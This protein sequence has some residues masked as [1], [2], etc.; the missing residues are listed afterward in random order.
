VIENVIRHLAH[1]GAEQKSREEVVRD[2]A[3]EV[4]K[5]AVFGQLI[6]MIVYLP[7]LSLEG[8]EGKMFRP[9]AMTVL[10][11]LVGSLIL[12]LTLMPVLA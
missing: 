9:M 7:I 12:S 10:L 11:V 5:P 6:I 3:I 2:A 1:G 4:R 8:V